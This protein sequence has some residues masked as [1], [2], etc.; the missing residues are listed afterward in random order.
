[1]TTA[2]PANVTIVDLPAGSPLTGS[3]LFE[4][5]QMTNGVGQ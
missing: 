2:L 4:A 3:E 5:V 1:M